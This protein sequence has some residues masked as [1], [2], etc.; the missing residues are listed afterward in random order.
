MDS[1]HHNHTCFLFFFLETQFDHHVK[2]VNH[3]G[4]FSF[5]QIMHTK[6]VFLEIL[7]HVVHVQKK[8]VF[9]ERTEY[10]THHDRLIATRRKYC[11]LFF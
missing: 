1:F 7:K 2:H 4:F 3:H 5:W 6:R 8:D 9:M 11:F 10:H